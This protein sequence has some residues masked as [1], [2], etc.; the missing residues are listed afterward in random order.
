MNIKFPRARGCI[1]SREHVERRL[2]AILAADVAGS[3]RL[4]GIDEEGTLTQLKALRKT[5]FDPKITDH[6]GRIVK[7]TGDGALVEFGSVVDAVRCAV[8]IQ[9]GMAKHNIDV[10][11]VKRIE[12][13]IGIHV[14][15]IIIEDHDIFG[16]GVNIATRL[17][18]LAEPGGIAVSANVQDQIA[19]KVNVT[20]RD[21]GPHEVKNIARPI[22]VWRWTP[23]GSVSEIEP[24]VG[25]PTPMKGPSIAVIP[26]ANLSSDKEVDFLSDGLTEDIITLLARLPGFFVIARYS[27]IGY[28]AGSKDVRAI[29]REL[30]VRYV[31]DGSIRPMA[32]FLRITIQL[33]DAE[34]GI[35]LWANRFDCPADQTAKLQDEVTAHIVACLQPELTQAEVKHAERYKPKT[36]DAWI[37]FRRAAA[38]LFRRGWNEQVFA[39]AI[40]LYHQAIARDPN[41]ALARAALSL[42]LALGHVT[43]VLEDSGEAAAEAERALELSDNDSEVLGYAGCA[44]SDLG[45]RDRAIA[46]LEHAIELNPSNAQAWVAL[47]TAFLGKGDMDQAVE[48]L[49][50][51]IRISPRDPRLALW[52]N[53]LAAALAGQGNLEKAVF[54]A[55]AACRYDPKLHLPRITLATLL[56]Q[57][58]HTEEASVVLAEAR[59]LRPTLR[60]REI[61][62]LVGQRGFEMLRPILGEG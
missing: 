57:A 54:E 13:R 28:K 40:G 38:S 33:I 37:L 12:F 48:K 44:I 36:V 30:G 14:S 24:M 3:C 53:F 18:T 11:Q 42:T 61:R 1:L 56:V 8:E 5:L 59:R 29:G 7:N 35:H 26:F 19:G 60:G 45:D 10:P 17:E 21:A 2:A 20:F 23:T 47:G 43:G 15:D 27:T 51:G 34:T 50:Y 49:S 9:R 6:R 52:I 4:I 31:V 22:A 39:E 32:E 58:G 55:R 16:D 46:I 62:A 41:F 25:P